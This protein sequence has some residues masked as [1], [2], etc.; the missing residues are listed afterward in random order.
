VLAKLDLLKLSGEAEKLRPGHTCKTGPKDI[1]E[2]SLIVHGSNIHFPLTFDDG[3]KWM[4]RLRK[5]DHDREPHEAMHM[6]AMSEAAT[7]Q[8][9]RAG[10]VKV[11]EVWIPDTSK[12]EGSIER[13]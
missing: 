13:D 2:D 5:I 6:T 12:G 8:V 1:E 9:L 4:V 7:Y 10:E 3:K 11:P